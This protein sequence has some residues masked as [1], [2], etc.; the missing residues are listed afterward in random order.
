MVREHYIMYMMDMMDSG[1]WI[2]VDGFGWTSL[3]N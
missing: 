2:R 1:R 3:I